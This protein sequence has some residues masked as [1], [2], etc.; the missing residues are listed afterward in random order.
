M[1][2]IDHPCTLSLGYTLPWTLP[3]WLC[4]Q[5]SFIEGPVW[6]HPFLS[7]AIGNAYVCFLIGRSTITRICVY[8]KSRSRWAG[9]GHSALLISI[10]SDNKSHVMA[11]ANQTNFPATA[12]FQT[13]R[14]RLRALGGDLKDRMV[15][16]LNMVL[17]WSLW[18]KLYDGSG[19]LQL[20]VFSPCP[21]G[22][23]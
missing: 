22:W 20:K 7:S 5:I 10:N 16:R 1:P 8:I 9:G 17:E 11:L 21:S 19:S 18:V 23:C 2:V 3:C 12:C 6:R 13:P 14:S 4:A 15:A